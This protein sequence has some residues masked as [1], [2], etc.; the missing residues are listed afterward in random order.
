MKP[1][2][3]WDAYA[4][5]PLAHE[6]WCFGAA[7]DELA[8]LTLRSI[9]TA[10]ASALPVFEAEGTTLPKPGDLSVITDS[11]GE[12]VC[13]I[14]TTRVDVMPFDKVSAEHAYLEGEDDRSLEAWRVAH[15]KFFSQELAGIGQTFSETLSV[16]CERYRVVYPQIPW[17]ERVN[18]YPWLDVCLLEQPGVTMDYKPEWGWFRFQV[19][20]KMFGAICQPDGHHAQVGGHEIVSLKCDPALSELLRGQYGDI[21]P[22]F[23]MD[24][25]NWIS[26]LLD[27]SV[28]DDLLGDLCRKA[29]RLVFE[30]LTKKAQREITEKA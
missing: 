11:R 9:K 3:M 20:G 5:G 23:Y 7:P 16:V 26:V 22:G 1:D 28:P 29:Y 4:G 24:K 8:A 19:G 17:E 27:G 10:T 12:A 2:E 21:L 30:R 18:R 25:R 15:R 13:I 14:E 6:T